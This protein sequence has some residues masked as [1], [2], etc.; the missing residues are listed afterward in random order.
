MVN[1]S[2]AVGEVSWYLNGQWLSTQTKPLRLKLPEY[3]NGDVELVAID[4]NGITV[5]VKFEV[6]DSLIRHSVI[7]LGGEL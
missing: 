6:K 3:L 4:V 2:G 5:R 7:E 1:V